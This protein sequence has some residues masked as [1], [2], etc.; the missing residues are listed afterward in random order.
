MNWPMTLT[1]PAG[2]ASYVLLP[3]VLEEIGLTRGK[4]QLPLYLAMGERCAGEMRTVAV[5]PPTWSSQKEP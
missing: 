5:K 1:A 4:K 3:M 2:R